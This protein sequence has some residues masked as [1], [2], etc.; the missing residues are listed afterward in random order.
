MP[1]EH[2]PHYSLEAMQEAVRHGRYG[3]TRASAEGAAALYLDEDDVRA[4]ILDLEPGHFYKTMPSRKRPG[5][6]QDV[7]RCRY[8]GFAIYTKL[9]LSGSD[10]AVVISFKQ[11]ES[12]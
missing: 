11:D 9:Q 1:P 5:A 10:A 7:Y 4:C 6:H 2:A 8:H 3:I 12:A